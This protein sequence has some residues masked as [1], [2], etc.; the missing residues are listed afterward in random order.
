MIFSIPGGLV[1]GWLIGNRFKPGYGVGA[2]RLAGMG[3]GLITR[4]IVIPLLITCMMRMIRM[5]GKDNKISAVEEQSWKMIEAMLR[6]Q[7]MAQ[8]LYNI[9]RPA[10]NIIMHK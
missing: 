4:T 9:L 3:I 5:L 7:M 2:N 6:P 8:R 1:G 10:S